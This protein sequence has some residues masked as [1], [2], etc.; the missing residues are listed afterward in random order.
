M[1]ADSFPANRLNLEIAMT[2]MSAGIVFAAVMAASLPARAAEIEVMTQNQYLGA[3]LTP[4]L[5]AATASYPT[6]E[7]FL[8]AFSAAVVDALRK[9]AS[10]RPTERAKSLAAEIDERHPDV[11]GLQ[12][13]YL[14]DCAPLLPAYPTSPGVGCDD[15]TI[16]GAFTDHLRDTAA[17]LREDYVV[18]GKVTNLNVAGIPFLVNGYPAVLSVADR[19]AILVRKALK[20][21]W[22]NFAPIAACA[23]PSDQ[24]C[25]YQTAP[26]ALSTPAG[27]IAIERGFLAVD[28]TVRGKPYRVFN[29]HLE[30][31][32]LAPNLPE[33][34]LLQ[35][36]Q[37]Y[38]LLGTAL[39]TWDGMKKVIVL[40]DMNSAP[41]DVIPVPPYPATLPW[42]P[43]LPAI[44]PYSVF[45]FNGVADAWTLRPHAQDGFSCCQAEDLANQR[46]QLS[47]RIDMV[48]ALPRPSRVEDMRLLGDHAARNPR[49]VGAGVLW[50]SDHAAVAATLHFD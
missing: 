17:A 15:P 4:V 24:G 37:A 27:T 1:M 7:A 22:V 26:P 43:E 25:N 45:T 46:S 48:F 6:P 5:D 10:T 12:E 47:E 23:K 31:R 40:G 13:A 49:L 29:T 44:P 8:A 21:S 36:G 33:T 16:K 2:T 19:D 42:A 20:A 14:F 28:V 38:E 50:P 35:V 18:A 34:R 32:L 39:G 3:D 30:Q 41:G 11:V 9:I